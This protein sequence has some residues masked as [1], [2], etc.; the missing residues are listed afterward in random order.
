[1]TTTVLDRFVRWNLDLDGGDLYGDDERERLRWYEGIV[2]AA[3]IQWVV[4]PWAAAIGVWLAGRDAILPLIAVLVVLAIPMG[5][6]TLYVRGKRVETTPRSWSP[7]RVLLSFLQGLPFV[8]F[9]IGAAYQ[10]N[11]ESSTWH[12]TIVG[13][14]IG[15]TVGIVATMQ[16]TRKRRREEAAAALAGDED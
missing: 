9:G 10:N 1:M 11:P 16:K 4:V 7:K 6:A 12:G 13:A 3:Q 5:V 2:T 8:V 15:G 14:A